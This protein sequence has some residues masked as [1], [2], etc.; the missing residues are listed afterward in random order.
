MTFENYIKQPMQMV[1]L[2]LKMIIAENPNLIN[3]LDRSI[4]HLL[5]GK[6]SNIPFQQYK[7]ICQ[8]LPLVRKI[9]SIVQITKMKIC[10][11]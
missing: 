7:C 4:N 2:K 1:Q 10:H 9:S 8:I 11:C 3:S 6:N 5:I